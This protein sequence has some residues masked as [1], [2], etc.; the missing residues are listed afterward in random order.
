MK[1]IFSLTAIALIASSSLLA[2]RGDLPVAA[3]YEQHLLNLGAFERFL[4]VQADT[5]IPD[6]DELAR[7]WLA[8]HRDRNYEV[9]PNS[10][11]APDEALGTLRIVATPGEIESE[12]I[13]IYALRD[14][15]GIAVGARV[16]VAGGRSAWLREA[17]VVED[18]L[19]H[20]VQYRDKNPHT[21]PTLSYVRYPVFI[22]PAS[23]Y[24]I[25]A[26]A[27]RLYWLTVSV[28]PGT[29][30]GTYEAAVAFTDSNGRELI[31]PL[32]IEVL[33]FTLTDKN[34]PKFGAFLSGNK[35]ASGE[36]EFMKRYGMDA[37]QWFWGSHKIEIFNDNGRVKMDFTSYDAMVRGMQAA[38][39][40]GPLVLSLGNSWLG[41]YEM[42]LAEEFDLRLMERM[43]DG[44]MVTMM[45]FKDPRWEKIWLE[46]LGVILDH[47][48]AAGW[49][50][51]ALLIHDEPTK[52][53]MAYH[54]YKYHLVKKH[55][56]DIP[57]YG[58]FFEPQKDPGPLLKS[59]DIMVAN[60]DLEYIKKLA[61]NHGKRFWSYG[62]ICADQSFGKNRLIYGQV[63]AY[64]ESEVMFFW[65]WNYY[66][67]NP[68]SDFDGRGE[69]VGGPAQS[70]A[71]WVAVYPSVD[72]VEPVRT[73]AIEAAREAIDDV[74][75]LR[76]LENLVRPQNPARWEKLREEIRRRQHA[77]FDGIFQDNRVFS[78]TDFFL[79]T[80]NDDVEELRDWV[81]EKI[82]ENL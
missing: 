72:G 54:P 2:Q 5:L 23:Q 13:S 50:E 39:M 12:P 56:P 74:R 28:P 1:S 31:V 16:A 52:F 75:Y 7:G 53:I 48:K 45:D 47:A 22:R 79:T 29:P 32:K 40:E 67:N 82:R 59:C 81:T 65:C 6:S 25:K 27:S 66:I 8:Y 42:A 61:E 36:F 9:L 10:K 68:W 37:L 43:F 62:N 17:A 71:D 21:W 18:V 34:L 14:V 63:P 11:P 44:R 76:T 41:H 35:L 69:Q 4:P 24:A 3:D 58:V 78:D 33:P 64:Y 38:G 30:A 73:L 46:G 55:F 19:F 26:G 15:A 20:P 80:E 70:D 51:L 49:P 57:V 77:L 60:R